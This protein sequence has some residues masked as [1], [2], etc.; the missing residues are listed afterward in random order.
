[1]S[2][3]ELALKTLEVQQLQAWITGAAIFLGP[4]MGVLYTMW[5]QKRREGREAKLKLFLAMLGE[6]KANYS[7]DMTRALNTIDVVWE[8]N[9]KVRELWHHYYRLLQKPATE[10]TGHVWLQLL[11]EM[12]TSLGYKKLTQVELDQFYTP[13]GHI[14]ESTLQ[15]N[16]QTELLRVL[17]GTEGFL[18]MQRQNQAG[19]GAAPAGPPQN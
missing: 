10:E 1:M 19:G 11:S 3:E 7:R 18:A 17:Q 13:Q 4:L 9:A 12:A 14:D 2:P 8:D 16:I 5:V 15:R 6:R